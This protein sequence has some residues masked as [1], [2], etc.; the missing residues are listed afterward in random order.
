[1]Q[2]GVL[3]AEQ[4]GELL[5]KVV[6]VLEQRAMPVVEPNRAREK[7]VQT[8][9]RIEPMQFAGVI[10]DHIAQDHA[11][12]VA[13]F[14]ADVRR[15]EIPLVVQP[16]EMQVGVE[17][18]AQPLDQVAGAGRGRHDH[19]KGVPGDKKRHRRIGQALTPELCRH[20]S[21]A[22]TARRKN[23]PGFAPGTAE[24]RGAA[25][26]GALLQP[27]Y[28]HGP[29]AKFAAAVAFWLRHFGVC[30]ARLAAPQI[31]RQGR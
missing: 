2:V 21:P 13:A 23:R 18:G 12:G 14:F 27:F 25:A 10:L 3:A 29:T 6:R 11:E 4:R 26:A 20:G 15:K 22:Q 30:F 1:M 5:A 19:G 17:H 24:R 16:Q 28:R 9:V 7:P 31:G 8:G